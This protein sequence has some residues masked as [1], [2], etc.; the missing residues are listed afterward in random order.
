MSGNSTEAHHGE[1][2]GKE[3]CHNQGMTR[4]LSRWI[5]LTIAA[6]VMVAILPGM[7]AIGEPPILGIAAFS[8][9]L[10]LIN[11][12][13]KPVVQLIALPL[14]IMSLGLFALIIN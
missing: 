9:F 8:L 1:T 13:I 12:S 6:G 14:S 7:E 10:A 11:A 2:T 3:K 5:V 4:F